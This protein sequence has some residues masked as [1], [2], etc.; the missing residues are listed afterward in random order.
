[1]KVQG[2]LLCLPL[3]VAM[4]STASSLP[5]AFLDAYT[6]FSSKM[7]RTGTQGGVGLYYDYYSLPG[8]AATSPISIGS[9]GFGMISVCIGSALGLFPKQDA[10][11]FTTESLESLLGEREGFTPKRSKRTNFFAHFLN[12]ETGDAASKTTE[13]S[14]I[15]TALMAAGAMFARNYL[16]DPTVEQKTNTLVRSIDWGAVVGEGPYLCMVMDGE[17]GDPDWSK[18]IRPFNEYYILAYVGKVVEAEMNKCGPATAYFNKY[19]GNP[20]QSLKDAEAA[21][22]SYWGYNVWSDSENR[23]ASSFEVQFCYYLSKFFQTNAVYKKFFVQSAAADWKYFQNVFQNPAYKNVV[24]KYAPYQW[25]CGAGAYP[26]GYFA[27]AI[28]NNPKLVYSAPIVAGFFPADDAVSKLLPQSYVHIADALDQLYAN[29]VCTSDV[30][31]KKIL[32]RCSLLE[33]DW[34]PTAIQSVD[35]STF[36]LGYAWKLAGADFFA[37][38]A[39]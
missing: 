8:G 27:A 25:G 18:K 3:V 4:A 12:P 35:F 21:N 28:D 34:Q 14:T 11:R 38:N 36:L 19:Y 39:I 33:K 10:I 23:F 2:T 29:Q 6:F 17:T 24:T 15:D 26:G 9:T 32:W 37:T 30:E 20:P 13:I 5:P 16:K 31:G 1:M 22:K 7:R